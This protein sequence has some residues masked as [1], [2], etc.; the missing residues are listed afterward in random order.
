MSDCCYQNEL[1]F[2]KL[3]LDPLYSYKDEISE[4]F[5]L[6]QTL[7]IFHKI[8][9]ESFFCLSGYDYNKF[10][11]DISTNINGVSILESHGKKKP[12][13]FL[14]NLYSCLKIASNQMFM[15]SNFN[16]D[17]KQMI[18]EIITIITSQYQYDMDVSVLSVSYE[19]FYAAMC[20]Q[21]S[22]QFFEIYIVILFEFPVT[23]FFLLLV[24]FQR[25]YDPN[26]RVDFLSNKCD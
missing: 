23:L 9:N 18:G 12:G 8:V 17:L 19:R 5:K 4:N 7:D 3:V 6:P 22:P 20:Q 26:W 13:F 14:M 24:S 21:L 25:R 1:S 16:E 2:L 15:F 10:S 11:S